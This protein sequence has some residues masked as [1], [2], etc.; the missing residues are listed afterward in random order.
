MVVTPALINQSVR[1]LRLTMSTGS[2]DFSG[3]TSEV[4]WVYPGIS[5]LSRLSDAG[6]TSRIPDTGRQKCCSAALPFL[7]ATE[8]SFQEVGLAWDKW[9]QRR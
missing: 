7:A 1:P 2:V 9:A 5:G 4:G 6:R 3:Y 8:D